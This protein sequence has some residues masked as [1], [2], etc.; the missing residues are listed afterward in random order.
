MVEKESFLLVRLYDIKF[1]LICNSVSGEY[2][3]TV[4]FF[5]D[6]LV[7]RKKNNTKEARKD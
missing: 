1:T 5:K 7:R 2:E 3:S 4:S 6:I